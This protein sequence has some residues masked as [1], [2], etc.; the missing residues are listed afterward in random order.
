MPGAPRLVD[1]TL[2][3]FRG[4]WK[5]AWAFCISVHYASFELSGVFLCRFAS[6]VCPKIVNDLSSVLSVGAP[7]VERQGLGFRGLGFGV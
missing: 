6:R 5:V 2:S 1:G 7:W 4:S 3:Y